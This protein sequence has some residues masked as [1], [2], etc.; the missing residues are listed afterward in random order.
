MYWTSVRFYE[1]GVSTGQ[2]LLLSFKRRLDQ[3]WSVALILNIMPLHLGQNLLAIKNITKLNFL[4]EFY[5]PNMTDLQMLGT[6]L[7]N[8]AWY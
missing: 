1:M 2:F 5:K 8:L 4:F 7:E 3:L 6:I